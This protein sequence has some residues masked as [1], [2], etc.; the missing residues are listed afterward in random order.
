MR[1]SF[2]ISTF[3]AAGACVIVGVA[4]ADPLFDPM[5][6]ANSV[7]ASLAATAAG[8]IRVE[9]IVNDGERKIAIVNGR[10]VRE[11]DRVGDATV[12]SISAG[13]VRFNRGGRSELISLPTSKLEVR[14]TA[15]LSKEPS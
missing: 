13:A 10:V 11:G 1:H 2:A 9:A 12:E 14:R 8:Q 7:D 15:T 5:R 4:A 6:P 3:I